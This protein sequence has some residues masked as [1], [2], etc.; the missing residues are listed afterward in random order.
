MASPQ[1]TRTRRPF[2]PDSGTDGYEWDRDGPTVP[3]ELKAYR[4]PTE[5]VP[6]TGDSRL[7]LQ[8][9]KLA[10]LDQGA[11][12]GW[13]RKF[14]AGFYSR[15]RQLQLSKDLHDDLMDAM[16]DTFRASLGYD[17]W[18]LMERQRHTASLLQIDNQAIE[19]RRSVGEQITTQEQIA[20]SAVGKIKALATL[21]AEIRA[22]D[23]KLADKTEQAIAA[24]IHRLTATAGAKIEDR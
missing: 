4:P 14:S 5:V 17:L 15:N 7:A 22:T 3:A 24:A 2:R 13:L 8:E 23:P 6:Y 11:D 12:G 18:L 19:L 9:Q 16:R 1:Q 10:V 21:Q 20:I